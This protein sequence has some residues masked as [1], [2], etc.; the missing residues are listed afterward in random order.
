MITNDLRLKTLGTNKI[1]YPEAM[2]AH[3]RVLTPVA[4]K[5]IDDY[6]NPENHR[7][8][9]P[10]PPDHWDVKKQWRYI[11]RDDQRRAYDQTA[12]YDP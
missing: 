6:P 9:V 10:D 4:A 12:D 5:Y 2:R 11:R 8:D 3:A 1:V 7:Y